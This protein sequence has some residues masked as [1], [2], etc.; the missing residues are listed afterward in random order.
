MIFSRIRYFN[1]ANALLLLLLTGCQSEENTRFTLLDAAATGVAFTNTVTETEQINVL[2]Y[3][4]FYN[5]G[6]VAAGDFNNDGLVDLYFTG[7]MVADQLYLNQGA[8]QFKDVTE[9]AGIAHGGWKT[10]V[11]LVDINNDGWLD[12]YVCRSLADDP[13]LRKNLLYVNEGAVPSPSKERGARQGGVRFQERAAEYGLADDSYSTQAAFFDY[14][15]DGDLDCFLLNHS[16]QEYAGFSNLI[17]SFREQADARFGSKLLRN[18]NGKFTDIT[19]QSGMVSNVLSFGLGLN[20]SDFNNDGWLDIYATNDYNENDYLYI[21]QMNGTFKE[22]VREAMGHTSFY[23]M[24]TDAADVNNDGWTDL[25]TLDMLPEP[26][27]RIKLTAGDDNYDKYQMLLRSGFH[28]Q[29]MRNML[30]LN[31][32]NDA[33]SKYATES[34]GSRSPVF[35][36]VGQLAGISNTD[37]SWAALFADFDNDGLKDLFVTNGYARDYTNMEFLKFS[38]DKQIEI[39]NG[40]AMPTEMEIINS[41]PAISEP[42]YIYK[43]KNGLTFE[44]KTQEWGFTQKS[45]SNGAAYADLDND[46][47]LDLVTNNINERA[48]IYQNNLQNTDGESTPANYL[49]IT[50]KASREALK[51]GAKVAVWV[52]GKGYF[53]EFQPVRGFQSAMYGPL[54]FGLNQATK[55]DSVTVNWTDG[56]RGS[57]ANPEP[58]RLLT[59]DYDTANSGMGAVVSGKVP[60]FLPETAVPLV[61]EQLPV[62]D[63]RTQTLLPEMR[64]YAGPCV[65]A[66]DANGDG[67][68]DVYAGGGRGQAAVLFLQTAN[69]F[70]KSTQPA[71]D[72]DLDFEDAAAT[73]FDADGDGDQDLTVVSSGYALAVGHPLLQPRLYLNQNGRFTKSAT[74]PAL[75][76]NARAVAAADVD[77]DGDQDIFVGANCVPGRYPEAQ[78]SVLWLNDGRGNYTVSK[79][80]SFSGLV[81]GGAFTDLNNDR[82][83]DLLLVGEW[84]KPTV[85]INNRGAFTENQDFTKSLEPSL[86]YVLQ[87]ADLDGDGDDDFV[88]GGAGLNSQYN[89]TANEG[90]R[91]YYGDFGENGRVVPVISQIK[92]GQEYPYASRDELLDQVPRLKKNYQNYLGYSTATT[93]EIFAGISL[94][95]VPQ[96]SARELRSGILWNDGGTLTFAPLPAEAQFAPIYA[97]AVGDMN[98]D[99]RQDL[100]LA[101]NMT[102]TRVRLGKS[103]ANKGQVLLNQGS[104][105]FLYLPQREAGLWVEGD[106]RAAVWAGSTLWLGVNGRA[107]RRFGLSEKALQ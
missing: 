40:G 51:I 80:F 50:L 60:L 11:S 85:F 47:D 64:S 82:Q 23:S 36:E 15:R 22:V 52:G 107:W 39:Q 68:E 25:V 37:W 43:N 14:D 74:V 63:F 13:E 48:F 67:R 62:N 92:N 96:L 35:A 6:G 104:R 91:M 54:H 53:Q 17:A 26:N 21:N 102:Q 32:G 97:V 7:N 86:S 90:L 3:G 41:M 93:D 77:G 71:F 79:N 106:V 27:D 19:A 99:G 4:Y 59:V 45:Q 83:P 94:P 69:G 58:N 44:K 24:G 81:S 28:D 29:T 57:L 18:D 100:V 88:V 78:P 12:I 9:A 105:N 55:I 20:V 1:P 103:D 34:R 101:G 2:K 98:G 10:G 66:G 33:E 5:G 30:Q 70:S 46:G 95:K 84:M 73:F 87:K 8:M 49:Q 31:L 75:L 16:V 56:R 89:I 76:V 42:N 38:T 61:H 65:A 72:T